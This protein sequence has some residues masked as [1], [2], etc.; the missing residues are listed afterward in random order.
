[1]AWKD[2]LQ[3]REKDLFGK[4]VSA[5]IEGDSEKAKMYANQCA[6]VRKIIRL[7]AGTEET[8]SMLS[9]PRRMN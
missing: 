4:C 6:E 7:V 2:K 1:V 3:A 5:Q 8:L 9:T